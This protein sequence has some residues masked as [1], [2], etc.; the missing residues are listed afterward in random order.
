MIEF[1]EDKAF[2]IKNWEKHQ[3]VEGMERLRNENSRRVA[4]YRAK[5]KEIKVTNKNS[6]WELNSMV[7]TKYVIIY[8]EIIIICR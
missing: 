7:F 3:N 5:N 2:K 1:T 8:L 4:K 6:F